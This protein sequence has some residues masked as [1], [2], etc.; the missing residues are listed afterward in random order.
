MQLELIGY[1]RVRNLLVKALIL[2]L[3]HLSFLFVPNGLQGV[4]LLAIESDR[5]V[6]ELGELRDNLLYFILLAKLATVWLQL[7]HDLGA[8]VEVE[9]DGG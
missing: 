9:V 4:D 7:H 1:L 5:I 6:D 3:G 2:V 8:S